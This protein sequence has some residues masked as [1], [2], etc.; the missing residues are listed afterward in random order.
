MSPLKDIMD[1]LVTM[2]KDI[3]GGFYEK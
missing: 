3:F 2:L 1:L